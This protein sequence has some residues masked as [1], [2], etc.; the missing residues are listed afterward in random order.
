MLRLCVMLIMINIRVISNISVGN[1]FK[2]VASLI[3]FLF[4]T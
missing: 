3:V 2:M 1:V 4:E